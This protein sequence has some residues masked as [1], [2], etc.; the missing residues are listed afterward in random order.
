MSDRQ[1]VPGVHENFAAAVEGKARPDVKLTPEMIRDTAAWCQSEDELRRT[2]QMAAA[3]LETA[4]LFEGMFNAHRHELLEQTNL[5]PPPQS[6]LMGDQHPDDIA[7]DRFAAAMKA[8]LAKKREEGRGRWDDPEQC[9][10][11]Y[12]GKLLVEH[13]EKGDPI[14]ICNFAMMIHQRAIT[15]AYH[16]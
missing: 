7:V 10:L 3:E 9:S 12:L 6:H 15:E 13:I 14:D 2:L 1:P 5:S 4:L 11:S 8:K 16:G